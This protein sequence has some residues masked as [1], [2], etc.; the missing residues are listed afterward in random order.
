MAAH[1][2]DPPVPEVGKMAQRD[3]GSFVVVQDNVSHSRVMAVTGKGN[4]GQGQ[5]VG[6][7][8]INGYE[9]FHAAL[10]Q[11]RSVA[12]QQL[13]IVT[14]DASKK[15]IVLGAKEILHSCN[16][17][18]AISVAY[19]VGN[20]SDGIGSFLSQGTGKEVGL[21]IKFADG[22]QDAIPGVHGNVLR[23]RGVVDNSRNRAR[24]ELDMLGDGLQ[25]DRPLGFLATLF[26]RLHL[27]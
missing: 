13:R 14:V 1:E 15:K 3:P 5:S 7:V 16:D 25:R 17:R 20:N 4:R 2:G 9:T 26:S 27:A 19:L 23:R 12:L 8:E 10:Q 22:G 6:Q 18:G 11:D 21:V 24:R